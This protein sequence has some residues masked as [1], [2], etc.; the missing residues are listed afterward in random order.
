MNSLLV[1]AD[2]QGHRAEATRARK[3]AAKASGQLKS[4]LQEIAAL[5]ELLADGKAEPD[6]THSP[7]LLLG[8]LK[9][10]AGNPLARFMHPSWPPE[11]SDERHIDGAQIGA[12]TILKDAATEALMV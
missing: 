4:E 5:Y 7:V 10:R 6:A 12:E 1:F 8:G 3:L 9:S 11:D 2:A